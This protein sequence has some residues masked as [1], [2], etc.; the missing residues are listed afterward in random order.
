MLVRSFGAALVGAHLAGSPG[1][2][3]MHTGERANR[4]LRRLGFIGAQGLLFLSAEFGRG[5]L[6]VRFGLLLGV[7]GSGELR[8]VRLLELLLGDLGVGHRAVQLTRT[9]GQR[10]LVGRLRRGHALRRA[11]LRRRRAGLFFGHRR[12]GF[13]RGLTRI[14]RSLGGVFDAL[15]GGRF[16]AL[17]Q[18]A[19][20]VFDPARLAGVFELL[21]L[22]HVFGRRGIDR[23]AHGGDEGLLVEVARLLVAH[24]VDLSGGGLTGDVVARRD[25]GSLRLGDFR[26]GRRVF[27]LLR[28]DLLDLRVKP[29][30]FRVLQRLELGLLDGRCRTFALH[31]RGSPGLRHHTRD[32][33]V[34]HAVLQPPQEARTLDLTSWARQARNQT[35]RT[36]RQPLPDVVRRWCRS[37]NQ[38]VFPR[39]THPRVRLGTRRGSTAWFSH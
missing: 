4:V 5:C 2:R 27:L 19:D 33:A 10:H 6:R 34:A 26:A 17:D 31:D 9:V 8:F 11:D 35:G 13:G 21:G 29:L 1:A 32:V 3:S 24:L 22:L 25:G 38:A 16:A 20:L 15:F 14:G 7:Q 12:D 36:G 30:E 23:L 28:L 37:V 39:S 18:A